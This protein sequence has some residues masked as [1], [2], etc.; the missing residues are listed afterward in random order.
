MEQQIL[1][2]E[3]Q[4]TNWVSGDAFLMSVTWRE[5]DPAERSGDVRAG[6]FF[7]LR[8]WDDEP[9]LS[10]PMSVFDWHRTGAAQTS[11]IETEFLCAVRGRGTALLS[12]LSV[13][14][15]I[16]LVGPFGNGW[17]L[18][19][20]AACS[21]V[22]VVGGGCG[23][24]PLF[25]AAKRLA[26]TGSKDGP[27]IDAFLGFRGIPYSAV[28]NRY[29]DV[30]SKVIVSSETGA[31]ASESQRGSV[32]AGRI[33]DAFDPHGYDM[34]LACGPRAMLIEI[35]RRCRQ[36]GVPVLVSLEERMAC[37]IG[38]CL[39]CAVRTARGVKHVC[40]DGPVFRS[41]EVIWDD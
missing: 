16:R 7:M 38:A 25:L 37:G 23:V 3:V 27:R 28:C 12:R 41:D 19:S 26:K 15:P 31:S 9:L 17:P 10:R 30:V 33:T 32:V 11:A 18:E 22:A 4:L 5:E 40:K 1:L 20:M 35:D 36:R 8:A 24:A 29:A 34:V 14:A 39:G 21:R 6:Q 2:A 13:G